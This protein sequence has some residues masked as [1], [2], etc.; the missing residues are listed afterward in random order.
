[1]V[2]AVS[3]QAVADPIKEQVR[4][5]YD[6][7]AAARDTWYRR[8]RFYHEHLERA[9]QALIPAGSSVLELGCGTGNLLAALR[10]S[11]VLGIDLSP[12]IVKIAR[13][14][15]PTL[16]LEVGDSETFSLPNATFD[17]VVGSD[18]VGELEDIA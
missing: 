11:R 7:L 4:E 17:F 1:M 16:S 5:H 12:E 2:T 18:L 9:L 10:P 3:A 15:H 8:G 13:L 14:N 6:R